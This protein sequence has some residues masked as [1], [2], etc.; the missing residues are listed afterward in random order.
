MLSE[1]SHHYETDNT[2]FLTTIGVPQGSVLS[3]LLFD[4]FI[5]DLLHLV[6]NSLTDTNA[7]LDAHKA[8]HDDKVVPLQMDADAILGTQ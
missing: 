7:S 4:I 2:S 3:P 5:D 8:A 6:S 1:T